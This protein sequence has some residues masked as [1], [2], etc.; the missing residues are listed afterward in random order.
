MVG[1]KGDTSKKQ[2]PQQHQQTSSSPKP[3]HEESSPSQQVVVVSGTNPFISSPL[4]VSTGASSSPFENQF[5]TTTLNTT[6]RPRYS[7]QWKLLPSPPSQQQQKQPQAQT[8]INILNPTT[9]SKS[10]TP[11]PSNPQQ[12]QPQTH[13]TTT[14]LAASSS[15]TTSSQSL[16]HLSPMPSQ[17]FGN[18]QELEQQVHQQLRKGKYVSP[19]WKPNEMLWL[20]RAW[21][22]QYQTGS[23]SSQQ[24]QQQQQQSELGMSRG[25][26]RADKDKEVAEFLN[27]HGVNR[28]AKTAGTKW[29]NMLGEFRKVYEWERGGERE[30]IGKSYFRLSPYER[31]LHRLPASFDE[32][33]FEEL[34]QFMGSRMRSSSHG[35]RI[36]SSSFVSCDETR[37]RSLPPPRPFKDDE[38]P[39]SARTKQLAVT[40]GG[41]EPFFHGHRG[42]ILGLDSMMEISTPCANTKELR[43]IGKIKMTWEESVS[44]WGE[45]GEVH[46]G[47]VRLQ[48]SS[49]LHADEITCF[50]DAMV[51]CPLESFEDGPLK[52]FSVDRFVS[53]Q[54]VKVF[55]RRKSSSTSSSGFAERVQPINKPIP[56]R[57][58]VPLDY[59]DPTEYYMD[60]LL[61]VSSPQSLPSLFELKHYLQEPP[62]PNLRFPLRKE[63]FEDLPQG[64]EFFFTTTSEPLDCRSIIYDIV[65]P[66]IRNN[67]NN[68]SCCT[69]PFSSRD[70]FIGVWDDC[71]NRVVSR[72][73]REDVVITRKPFSY[74]SNSQSQDTLLLLQDEW[75][76]VSG[77]VNNFCLWRGEEC[78]EFKENHIQQ[79]NPSSSIIQKLLW[80]YLDL[81]YILGYYAIGN[82]VTFCAISKSQEDG[83]IIRTDLHQVNLTTPSERFKALVPC[84]RIGI[85]LSILSRQCLTMQKGSFVY[86]DFERY[87]FGNGVIIE[88]TPNTCKRVYS[89]KRKWCSVKE[90]YEILDHRIPHSEFLFKV[91][92]DIYDMSLVFK[93]RGIRV[94]PLN[95]E[96]LVEA[97]KYVT[98]A[99]V[100][101]H[102]LSFMHRDLG[103]ENVMMREGGEWFVSGFDEAAGAPELNKYVKEGATAER[104]RHAPEMERG[105]HGVKVDVWGVGYLIMTSGLMSVPKMLRELQNWCME[106]NPEQRPTAADCYHHLLQLQSSLMVSGGVAGGGGLM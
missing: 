60:H 3:P 102:D 85:L 4:Y 39:L 36:G 15:D 74:W 69:L 25:K 83:K 72:F 68:P 22:E 54:Q 37:T 41:G 7:G 76:N 91:V 88:M 17:E 104:G 62:L 89:E 86:S 28:D 50:D 95:I 67:N 38:L 19:V 100:A 9:E 43:R 65:G 101:L 27:K 49:F 29:D 97:L 13:T 24:Q 32:E 48:N 6:K 61:H 55:G 63:V 70:S 8:Q 11:S 58:I 77:F 46:R 21:K 78:E 75:P 10:T 66:I 51:I 40:S 80:S 5:E 90:V 14:P 34:S 82:K 42:N 71:I 57:S 44:L 18:K 93:P 23:D 53:G 99:L 79:Q 73:C 31:K 52:G 103:W 47:R 56:I 2:Q 1:D 84:F 30:Q 26:T 94:K 16:D 33:V 64:K 35:G 98:K 59:R 20:A 87:S 81:P 92:E 45:E 105:L 96:Q 106:Q 12:Q